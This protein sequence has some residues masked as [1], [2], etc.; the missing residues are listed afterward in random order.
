MLP[1]TSNGRPHGRLTGKPPRV[2]RWLRQRNSR[3]LVGRHLC[4]PPTSAPR[5]HTHAI[6]SPYCVG[7]V[8]NP[9]QIAEEIPANRLTS[10]IGTPPESEALAGLQRSRNSF[11]AV[12]KYRIANAANQEYRL[13]GAN[14]Q[15]T[16]GDSANN[17]LSSFRS[18]PLQ[19]A[20][21]LFCA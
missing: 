19:S 21:H 16:A 9:D 12:L 15:R 20:R 13:S 2:S 3:P 5:A 10:N 4:L 11:R 6:P 18:P 17:T 1:H 7:A 8:Q 14:L